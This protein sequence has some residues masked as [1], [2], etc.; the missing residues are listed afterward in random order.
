MLLAEPNLFTPKFH[1][2]HSPKPVA[3]NLSYSVAK[4]VIQI[5]KRSLL[6]VLAQVELAL[7]LALLLRILHRVRN[8]SIV[9]MEEVFLPRAYMDLDPMPI[10]ILPVL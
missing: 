7:V 1:P 4:P 9:V 3:R 5:L 8:Y 2:I 10:P 6:M